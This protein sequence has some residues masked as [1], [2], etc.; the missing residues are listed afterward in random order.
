[1]EL[2]NEFTLHQKNI[3]NKKGISLSFWKDDHKG[4]LGGTDIIIESPR[5]T[6]KG[7]CESKQKYP[8]HFHTNF[9]EQPTPKT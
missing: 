5:Q 4:D 7:D 8:K 2:E 9:T 1:M 6:T 3:A